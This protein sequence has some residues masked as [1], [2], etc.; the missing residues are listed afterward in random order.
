VTISKKKRDEGRA[1]KLVPKHISFGGMGGT[2]NKNSTLDFGV[3]EEEKDYTP[4]TQ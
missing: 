1:S 2:Y 3:I 4:G